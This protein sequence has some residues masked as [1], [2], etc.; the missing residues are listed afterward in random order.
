MISMLTISNQ[1]VQTEVTTTRYVNRYSFEHP[2]RLIIPYAVTLIGTLV[3]IF[4]GVIALLQNGVSASI[5]GFI[6]L[7]CT[8]KGSQT[9]DDITLDNSL[10]GE[11]ISDE[12]KN[13][14]VKYGELK[15]GDVV[16][17][18]FG[19]PGE[20]RDLVKGRKYR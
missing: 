12:L 8:T 19:V 1:D 4:L 5:G 3:F 17:R 7:L 13:L 16:R 9:L 2:A 11:N 15:N 14:V 18:G 6:Q 20:V 10:G